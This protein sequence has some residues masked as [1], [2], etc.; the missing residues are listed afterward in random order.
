MVQWKDWLLLVVHLLLLLQ[1]AC[2]R[3]REAWLRL[4]QRR[5]SCRG[6]GG[7]MRVVTG[8]SYLES[9][10]QGQPQLPAAFSSPALAWLNQLRADAVDRVGA[11]TVPATRDGEG[12]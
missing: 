11:L 12:G 1:G 10:L 2:A 9:L 5:P 4:G 7:G 6:G 8:N 3:A